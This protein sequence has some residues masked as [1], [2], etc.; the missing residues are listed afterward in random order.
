MERPFA[1]PFGLAES[2]FGDLCG[3]ALSRSVDLQDLLADL[4]LP[5]VIAEHIFHEAD[6]EVRHRGLLR[7]LRLPLSK[8][9]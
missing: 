5:T 6:D 3:L 2:L 7:H 1:K 4:G 9:I 8:F